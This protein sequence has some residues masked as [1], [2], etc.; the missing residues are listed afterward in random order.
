VAATTDLLGA[1]LGLGPADDG[2]AP[3]NAAKN[4]GCVAGCTDALCW[5]GGI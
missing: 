2:A 5:A 3:R 4:V 1:L